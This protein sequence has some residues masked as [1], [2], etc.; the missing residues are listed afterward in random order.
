MRILRQMRRNAA[1]VAVLGFVVA[2]LAMWMWAPR[3]AAAARTIPTGASFNI[4]VARSQSAVQARAIA[5]QVH[6]AGFP[7]FT[8]AV[9]NGRSRDVIVGPYVSVEEADRA[10]RVLSA[11]GFNARMLVDESVR[12][13]PGYDG[14]PHVSSGVNVLL[15]AAAGRLS[16]VLE[17]PSEPR[18]VLNRVHRDEGPSGLVTLEVDA[19]PVSRRVDPQEWNA[20]S[21]V[22]WM[23]RI[24]IEEIGDAGGRS[25]RARVGLVE[26]ARTNVRVVGTRVYIDLWMPDV[27]RPAGR[28]PEAAGRALTARQ[29]DR[30]GGPPRDDEDGSFDYRETIRPAVT[31]LN[32]MEPF[33]M[34][35]IASQSPEVLAA[36]VRTVGGLE[37]W[38]RT[39]EAPPEWVETHR[40]LIEAAGRANT[41]VQPDFTGDRAA[42][43]HEA[44]ALVN[45]Q[46]IRLLPQSPEVRP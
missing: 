20:P 43:A 8:R 42:K 12:R 23:D 24:S 16:V 1:G 39:V 30:P 3:S 11:G 25:I 21:G 33:V 13:V 40:I 15:V 22:E 41:A 37:E 9:Q 4:S 28:S 18:Q 5:G 31:R 14:I 44:F 35:A 36:L 7:A 38:L 29:A 34:S 32:N 45:Q 17:M 10:Q 19:G 2:G 46:A 26:S 6:A 27:S